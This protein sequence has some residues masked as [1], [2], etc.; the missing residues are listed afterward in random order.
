MSNRLFLFF[1][2]SIFLFSVACTTKKG[3]TTKLGKFY[4]NVTG[5]YNAYYNADLLLQKGFETQTQMHRD[6]YNEILH[7]FPYAAGE[8]PTVAA[9]QANKNQTADPATDPKSGPLKNNSTGGQPN[10]AA[11]GSPLDN[12]IKKC[13]INIELHRPSNWADDSYFIVGRVEFLKKEFE[14]SAATFK[15]ITEKYHTNKALSEMSPDE[16]KAYNKA[17][18][19]KNS[20]DKKKSKKKNT[21]K[22]KKKKS[23]KKK[24]PNSSKTKQTTEKETKTADIKNPEA[25]TEEEEG[26]KPPKYFLKHRPV[27]YDAMLWM[28]KSYIELDNYDDAGR[29]LRLLTEKS[30]VPKRIK[31]QAL[32]VLAYSHIRQKEFDKA[33]EPLEEGISMI[34]R[35]KKKT[36]F[37]YVLGQLYQK[38]GNNQLAME[39]FRKVPKANPEYEMEFNARLNM[40]INAAAAENSKFDPETL[41]KRMLRDGKNEEYKDQIYFAL[42]KMQLNSGNEDGGI[43]ALQMAMQNADDFQKTEAAYMLAEIFWKRKDY[44]KAYAYFD[45]CSTAIQASDERNSYVSAQKLL[46]KDLAENINT[47]TL[48]DSLLSI[49]AWPYDKQK[50]LVQKLRTEEDAAKKPQNALDRN[51]AKSKAAT[52]SGINP[53]AVTNSK[54][55]LYDPNT[56]KKGERDFQKRWGDRVWTDN[57]RRSS[58]EGKNTNDGA[59]SNDAL[60]PLTESEVKEYLKKMGVPQDTASQKKMN[61]E[62]E[63]ALFL[64]GNI[65][66]E[67]LDE[68]K[69]ASDAIEKLFARYP[70]TKHELEAWFLMFNICTEDKNSNCTASYKDKILSAYADSDIAKSLKD[71]NYLNAKQRQIAEV[72]QYYD[73]SYALIKAGNFQEAYRR[74]EG[75]P[76]KFGNNYP[77]KARF[78]ILAAMCIGGMQGQEPYISALKSVSVSYPNTEEDKKAK[79]MVALLQGNKADNKT[80]TPQPVKSESKEIKGNYNFDNDLATGHYVLV[81]FDDAKTNLNDLKAKISDF[82][83]KTFSL[84][85]LNVSSLMLDGKSPTLI[86]R[87]FK[88]RTEAV[89]YLKTVEGNS[90]FMGKDVPSHKMYF[91]GQ[92]NYREILQKQNFGDYIKFYDENFK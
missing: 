86:V 47:I 34:R 46:L 62:I 85:R 82:N 38:Q 74:Y 90:E 91:I 36:R 22:K 19:A 60:K 52:D 89:E 49:A 88:D 42:A 57:W 77:L 35:K 33:I 23:N 25:V 21:K 2:V 12:A 37:I 9:A 61:G 54:F 68:N 48:K 4:H 63:T 65:Y 16:L 72:N 18:Q 51:A 53:S 8:K 31:A 10:A 66:Y 17:Q 84:L 59:E 67:K 44:V 71:P 83:N 26:P 80:P 24:K 39:N 58:T 20:K 29:Y 41:L 56:S 87:K 43:V 78:A 79:E 28:A 81:A 6:N 69:R 92:N 70:K 30:D 15:Y 73:D 11:A 55:P 27:R 14:K 13:A 3:E 50:E 45:T 1:A 40:A 64:V 32:T 76:K 5:R 7:M 75:L